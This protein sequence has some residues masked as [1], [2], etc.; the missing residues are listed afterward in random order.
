MTD[1]TEGKGL[2]LTGEKSAFQGTVDKRIAQ[3][4]AIRDKL[5]AMDEAHEKKKEP[6]VTIQ[7]L[8]TGWMMALLDK[9]GST[10]IKTK[11]G[12]CIASTR[13]TASLADPSVFMKYVIDNQKFDL[14]DRRANSTAVKEYVQEHSKLP[15]GVNMSAIRT[16]GVRRK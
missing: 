6:L 4:I 2:D 3:Y 16:L 7:N 5:K 12:T 1:E 13:Y 10:S 9:T 14:L 11:H 8:L 15:P